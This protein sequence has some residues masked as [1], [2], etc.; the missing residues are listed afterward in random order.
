MKSVMPSWLDVLH[1]STF[2]LVAVMGLGSLLHGQETKPTTPAKTSDQ[3][4]APQTTFKV[5]T[6]M[7]TVQVVIRD[8]RGHAVPGLTATDFQ[9]FEQVPPKKDQRQQHIAAFQEVNVAAIAAADKGAVQMPKGVF[10]N[11]VTMQKVPVPPTILVVDGLNTS[12]AAE[13]Q[14]HRQMVKLLASMPTDIPV[15]VFLL[16]RNL[17]LI[18]NFTTDPTL[19]RTA[20][21]RTL[22]VGASELA[23][24]DVR[25]D[26]NAL[27]T[28]VADSAP[29]PPPAPPGGA[30]VGAELQQIQRGAVA[31]QVQRLQQFER[32]SSSTLITTR[33]QITLDAFRA[34]ARHVA[35]YP[36]RKNLLWLSSSFPLA[37]FPDS[38]FK[39]AGMGEFQG[40]LAG[41]TKELSDAKIALYPID[42]SGLE[43]QS[44]F[45]ASSRPTARNAAVGT[46]TAAT[47]MREE[48]NRS[49]SQQS[50]RQLAEQTGGRVCVNN[51][52][53]SDCVKKAVDDGSSYYE[54][55]YYPDSA[56]WT[57]EFHRITVKTSK[58]GLH[59][60]FREGYYARSESSEPGNDSGKQ[61]QDQLQE[62]ACHDMLTST[63][64]LVMTESIPPDQ[65]GQ[66]KYFIA[67]DP[68]LI[69]FAPT[70]GG[71]NLSMMIAACT[72]DKNGNALQYLQQPTDLNITEQQYSSMMAQHAFSQTLGF[73]PS[74]STVRVRLLVRDTASGLMGSVD[75]PYP[76]ASVAGIAASAPSEDNNMNQPAPK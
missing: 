40:K 36:G 24:T 25:E 54:L 6:R 65:P 45:D 35:G 52:D 48:S 3:H 47:V 11:L 66:A 9:V 75:V 15:A 21:Q 7:V 8:S 34:I 76:S 64:I 31:E 71:R 28:L 56:N 27:A 29:P 23:P 49:S 57:G 72:F 59:L 69:S 38:D 19:L 62:A 1:V 74:A 70:Q 10:S 63:A 2:S 20:V 44:F 26:P 4:S 60:A 53:L 37:I 61:G 55:A 50:M 17:H 42:P 14:I 43:A 41:L 22:T 46:A 58:R 30:Q 68:R 12:T 18:Q 73:A 51:N 32:E 5:S 33:V 16:D 13:M 67:V 39:F